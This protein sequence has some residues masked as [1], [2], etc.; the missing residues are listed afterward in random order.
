M[1]TRLSVP[2]Y[3]MCCALM[4]TPCFECAG[5]RLFSLSYL[6]VKLAPHC[7]HVVWLR[8][9]TVAEQAHILQQRSCRS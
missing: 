6:L 5:S 2:C 9:R 3:V 4:I 7:H 8:Q 1:I